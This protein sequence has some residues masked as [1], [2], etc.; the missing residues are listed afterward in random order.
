MA[1]TNAVDSSIGAWQ[2]SLFGGDEPAVDAEF[3]SLERIWLDE[4]SWVDHASRWLSGADAVLVELAETLPWRQR[5]VT[6]YQ[7]RLPEPRLTAWWSESAPVDEPIVLLAEARSLLSARYGKPFDSIGFNL[8]RDGRDSVAW[9]SDRERFTHEDP[10]VVILSTGAPRPFRVRPV[11]GGP[12]RS[13]L[14]GDGDLLVMGGSCQ[15]N[16]QHCV[17]KT[18]HAQGPRLSIMF[19]HHLADITPPAAWQATWEL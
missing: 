8:Y 17:P 18:S 14:L 11:G 9:H 6:M 7:R 13:W 4:E 16:W 2:T 12:S 3:S 19:R 15:H 5:E 1:A 10:V